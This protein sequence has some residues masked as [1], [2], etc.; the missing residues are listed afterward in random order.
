[1]RRDLSYWNTTAQTWTLPA[2]VEVKVCI[3]SNG[4]RGAEQPPINYRAKPNREMEGTISATV[5]TNGGTE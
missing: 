5:T 1:M 3:R 2:A 4:A